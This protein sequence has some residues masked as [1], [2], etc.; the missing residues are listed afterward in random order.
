MTADIPTLLLMIVVS[1]VVVAGALLVLNGNQR[2]D[3]L[4][5]WAIALLL[6]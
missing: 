2:R 5:Y 6:S 3:G 4:Q 1:S